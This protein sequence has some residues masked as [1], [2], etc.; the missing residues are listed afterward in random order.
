MCL[1]LA[2]RTERSADVFIVCAC[3]HIFSRSVLINGGVSFSL[4]VEYMYSSA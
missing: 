3:M 1:T 2:M 4:T